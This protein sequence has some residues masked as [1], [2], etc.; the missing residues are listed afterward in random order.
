MKN[1]KNILGYIGLILL[2]YSCTDEINYDEFSTVPL[3]KN[4]E[5]EV[6]TD[7]S[8]FRIVN[9]KT[10]A[11]GNDF[12]DINWGDGPAFDR[13]ETGEISHSY[14]SKGDFVIT[15]TA[16]KFGLENVKKTLSVA[17]GIISN[18]NISQ[19]FV[20]GEN[21]RVSLD[22]SATNATNYDIDWG[23]GTT[24]ENFSKDE[25]PEHKYGSKGEYEIT[26]TA[27]AEGFESEV[28][29]IFNKWNKN[30]NDAALSI[31]DDPIIDGN[32]VYKSDGA[33]DT[34]GGPNGFT[35]SGVKFDNPTPKNAIITIE[36]SYNIPIF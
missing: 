11:E 27:K 35:G 32:K 29:K 7:P 1:L 15:V 30:G 9:L 5:I 36:F 18:L 14:S 10:T 25:I 4:V 33:K 31:A 2:M 6:E 13:T 17:V 23:D 28:K 22:L 3:I 16:R 19:T 12:F 8:D 21:D 26:V 24:I 34:N 20:E